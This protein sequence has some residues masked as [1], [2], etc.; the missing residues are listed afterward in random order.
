MTGLKF[1]I[2]PCMDATFGQVVKGAQFAGFL[3]VGEPA[4]IANG[5]SVSG[6]DELCFLDVSASTANKAVLN[7]VI[8]QV[9]ENCFIPLTVG[10]GVRRSKDVGR[11]LRAGA[12]KVSINS[13][14]VASP[15]FIATCVDKY[16]SQ[17]IVASVDCKAVN[18]T[19]EVYSHG[20]TRPTGIDALEYVC[21]AVQF[22]AGEILLTSIDK[23]GAKTGYDIALVKSVSSL[24]SVPVIA[25]GGSG[26]LRHTAVALIEG[27]ASAVLLASLLHYNECTISQLKF[28][29]GCCGV[30]VRDDYIRLGLYDE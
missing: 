8:S 30:L 23:D 7:N 26:C 19:W 21:R 2:I 14:G 13:A 27:G 28:L 18:G 17:C 1:R 20:G 3:N 22:G 10:G 4:L 29:L 11:L 6:A 24:V 5:Y 15:E 12:D 16:G 25:S 9:A